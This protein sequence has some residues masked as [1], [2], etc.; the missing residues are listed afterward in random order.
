ML[1]FRGH[2]ILIRSVIWKNAIP[3]T[4]SQA[5]DVST[6]AHRRSVAACFTFH[7]SGGARSSFDDA[8]LCRQLSRSM[9]GT[10]TAS[11]RVGDLLYARVCRARPFNKK[12]PLVMS[13]QTKTGRLGTRR[14]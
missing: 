11:N 6:L 1:I 3:K 4:G 7:R 8:C 9:N 5:V 13:G 14:K 10:W 12:S 2:A